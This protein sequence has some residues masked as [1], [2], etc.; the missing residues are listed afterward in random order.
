MARVP[1]D[2]AEIGDARVVVRG[3]D[4]KHL[5]RVLRLKT[6]DLVTAFDGEGREWDARVAEVGATSVTLALGEERKSERESSLAITLGQGIGKGEKLELVLRAG[7]E[8]GVMSFVPVLT[9]RAVAQAEGRTRVERWR[10][11]AAEACK[12]CG[13]AKVPDVHAP[14]DLDTF[15]ARSAEAKLVAWEGGGAPLRSL[16]KARSV[17]LLIGPEGGLSSKEVERA[18]KAG[19]T[20]I[21]L[22]PRILRTETAGIALVTALQTLWGDLG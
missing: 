4:A 16:P 12:Q 2:A 19:F 8:L 9:E 13:R 11:I 15:L 18:K 10:K 3:A 7:T 17:S 5:S 22:G 6:G 14:E 20:P 21:S 1:I